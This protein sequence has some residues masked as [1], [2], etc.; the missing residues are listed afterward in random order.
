M[1]PEQKTATCP[2]G[3]Q[4]RNPSLTANTWSFH[5]PQKTCA[6][7]PLRPHCCTGKGGR[8]V[9][10]NI[11]YA[12]VQKARS[13]QKTEAFKQDYHQHRSGV[14][15]SLSALVRGHGLR[16]SRYIGQKKRNVQAIL[17]GCAANLKRTARWLSGKRPQVRYTKSW[18]L[19]PR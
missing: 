2:Q 4:A 7:C 17:T 6:V 8:T 14:E 13:R 15:G 11:H 18:T 9:G 5:F 3:H 10:M 12:L 16:V 1:D 19:N